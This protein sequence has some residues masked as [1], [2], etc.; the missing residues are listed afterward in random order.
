MD[1]GRRLINDIFNGNRIL[2]IPFFQRAYVWGEEQ[3]ERVLDDLYDVCSSK[4]TH[5]FGSVILKQQSTSAENK[6]GDRRRV[7]D[8][9]QRLTTLTIFF[10]V[11][12]MKLKND[13]VF[14]RIFKLLN[15]DIALT[16][17]HNDIEAFE[18]IINYSNLEVIDGK[19]SITLCF[20]YFI[21]NLDEQKLDIDI[22]LQKILFV[23]ID[24][25]E[26]E[27]EQKI[28]DTINSLG[29]KLTTA[30]LLKNFFF[31]KDNIGMYESYWKNIFETDDDTKEYWDTE[32]TTGRLK[33]TFID[34]FLFAYLQIKMNSK[35]YNVKT[36]DKIEFSRVEQLFQSYKSFIKNY[37]HND[38]ITILNELK[39]YAL[40]FRNNFNQKIIEDDLPK[41][42]GIERINALI[43]GLD[44]TPL[45]PY[46]LFILKENYNNQNSNELFDFIEAYIIRRV[47]VRAINKNY[48]QLFSDR[49]ILNDIKTKDGFINYVK[50]QDDKTNFM[51]SDDDLLKGFHNSVLSNKAAAGIL[52]LIE[53]KIR[54]GPLHSTRLLGISKYSLEHI[55]PKKW[56][57]NWGKLTEQSDI[58]KRNRKLLTLGNLAIIT[59]NL[60]AKIRDANWE[61][62]KNGTDNNGL[63]VYSGNLE[64]IASYLSLPEWDEAAIEKRA[65]D[66][67]NHAVSIWKI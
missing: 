29:V 67:Y 52:Y 54:K 12:C 23:G 20:N 45:I 56:E 35:K 34:L 10:K 59:Q 14:D 42:S 4:K 18:K 51:P 55:M 11:L 3:W 32:I 36:E 24:L 48:N 58:D 64:T 50:T 15:D 63:I 7:I 9:Q 40:L 1:A 60:N 30:E 38:T 41:E 49:L 27:D 66:L 39:E 16:H 61:T 57:N 43:F 62:K 5:F 13:K 65:I 17:N 28:F 33:R 2:E 25:D 26:N 37:M 47:I 8:G 31:N 6:V 21:D 19:D 22:I 53:T 46:V 44:N